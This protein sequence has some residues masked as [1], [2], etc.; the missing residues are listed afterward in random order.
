[1]FAAVVVRLRLG[2]GEELAPARRGRRCRRPSSG[3]RRPGCRRSCSCSR[4]RASCRRGRTRARAGPRS[5]PDAIVSRRSSTGVG[6]SAPLRIGADPPGLLGHVERVVAVRGPPS[7]SGAWTAATLVS[8]NRAWCGSGAAVVDVEPTVVDGRARR[9]RRRLG[10]ARA[11]GAARGRDERGDDERGSEDRRDDASGHGTEPGPTAGVHLRCDRRE[12]RRARSRRLCRR[13]GR[14]ARRP[15]A[16]RGRGDAAPPGARRAQRGRSRQRD[17]GR[18]AAGQR[19]RQPLDPRV[20]PARCSTPVARRSRP[21]RWASSSGPTRSRTAATSSR[22]G[23]DGTMVDF[24]AGHLSSEQSHPIV[25][26]LDAALGDGRD[27]VRF[28]AGVEYRHL[29]VVPG[30]LGRRRLRAAARP[31]RQARGLADRSRR[32]APRRR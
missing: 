10:R 8:V 15:D 29:V 2:D 26:A 7:P 6:S 24:A 3:T 4:R 32:A 30:R 21:R 25:A 5:P 18:P 1:M 14:R 19:R 11:V 28:H 17:P 20:R 23:A 31:H 16:A 13:A 12:V 9:P 22:I 27:G